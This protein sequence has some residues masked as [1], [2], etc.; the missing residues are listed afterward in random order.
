MNIKIVALQ[1]L[2]AISSLSC[3]QETPKVKH[4]AK[5]KPSNELKNVKVANTE[6]PI[7]KMQTADFLKDTVIYKGKIYGFCS[8]HCKA[9]FKKN[10]EKYVKIAK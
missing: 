1:I 2:I 5:M 4:V 10:P 9:E 7:C 3:A 8:D 6:D